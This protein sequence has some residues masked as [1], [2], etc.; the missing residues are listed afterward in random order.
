M[1]PCGE[2][3]VEDLDGVVGGASAGVRVVGY[4]PRESRRLVQTYD[5]CHLRDLKS[6]LNLL[7]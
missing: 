3:V 6:R 7:L 1:H 4:D 5:C 2:G